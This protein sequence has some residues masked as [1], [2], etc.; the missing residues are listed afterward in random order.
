MPIADAPSTPPGRTKIP[1]QVW[2]VIGALGVVILVAA[3]FAAQSGTPSP[4]ADEPAEGI[5]ENLVPAEG[6]EVLQQGRFG[7]DLAPGWEA[8]LVVNDI[9]IPDDQLTRVPELNQVFFVPG[10]GQVITTLPPGSNCISA[11]FWPSER[12]P[13][14][15]QVR[16]WCFD[17]T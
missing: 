5:I 4:L 8:T 7:I 11:R 9:Q 12:G 15:S 10:E 3:Y 2:A 1:P 17:V 6:S 13:E 14:D 16:T